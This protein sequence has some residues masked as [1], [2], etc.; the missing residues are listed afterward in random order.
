MQSSSKFLQFSFIFIVNK[1]LNNFED[2]IIKNWNIY[3][4]YFKYYIRATH[5][6]PVLLDKTINIYVYIP[7]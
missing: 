3:L 1:K 2:T 6:N 5:F 7:K 4:I